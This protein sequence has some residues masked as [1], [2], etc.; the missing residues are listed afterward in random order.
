M[1]GAEAH[2]VAP[3][4]AAANMGVLLS[5]PR[6]RRISLDRMRCTRDR[7][8]TL[9]A[10]GV[11]VALSQSEGDML[12]GLRLDAGHEFARN[13]ASGIEAL[14][15]VTQAPAQMLGNADQRGIGALMPM[16]KARLVVY[17][18]HP[19][20]MGSHALLVVDGARRKCITTYDAPF[21]G[22]ET[23]NSFR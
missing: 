8:R 15:M 3:Q 6:C 13:R 14:R 19:L 2:L 20:L 7:V 22:H 16:H 21:F 18:A 5:Q 1:G 17:N 4:L 11:R 10:A 23:L 12:R 9:L